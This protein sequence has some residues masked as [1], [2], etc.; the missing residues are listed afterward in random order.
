MNLG[1]VGAAHRTRIR[2]FGWTVPDEIRE[3]PIVEVAAGFG[4][5]QGDSVLATF[6]HAIDSPPV[7]WSG[8]EAGEWSSEPAG[9]CDCA[10]G[11]VGS[12]VIS[13]VVKLALSLRRHRVHLFRFEHRVIDVH[14]AVAEV[15]CNLGAQMG[16]GSGVSISPRDWSES[17][18]RIRPSTNQ[19]CTGMDGA[20]PLP[21][22]GHENAIR[23]R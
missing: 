1:G 2:R 5:Q 17:L 14:V 6:F 19:G 23:K 21:G 11:L 4:A 22:P 18:L 7:S 13:V 3:A 20:W 10:S 15:P 8:D 9:D 16:T 12:L